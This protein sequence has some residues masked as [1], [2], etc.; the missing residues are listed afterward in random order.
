MRVDVRIVHVDERIISV[1][2]Y[3][4]RER[5]LIRLIRGPTLLPVLLGCTANVSPGLFRAK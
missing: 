3:I 1:D 4:I 5:I 2:Y